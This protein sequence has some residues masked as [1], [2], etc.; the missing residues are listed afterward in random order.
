MSS[1]FALKRFAAMAAITGRFSLTGTFM[2]SANNRPAAQS[3]RVLMARARA[4]WLA[5]PD[6]VAT[7]QQI[8]TAAVELS[9]LYGPGDSLIT[10]GQM[11]EVRI[12]LVSGSLRLRKGSRLMADCSGFTGLGV[13][14]SRH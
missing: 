1:V 10:A 11:K 12:T 14:H 4:A 9:Q 7:Q 6:N 5:A 2:S 13:S 3:L 8:E